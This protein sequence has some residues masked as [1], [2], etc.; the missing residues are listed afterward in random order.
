MSNCGSLR[1]PKACLNYII[2]YVRFFIVRAQAKNLSM[3]RLAAVSIAKQ[4]SSC[5]TATYRYYIIIPDRNSMR[6]MSQFMTARSIHGG[7]AANSRPPR[8]Q[9]IYY[10]IIPFRNSSFERK[11]RTLYYRASDIFT[12]RRRT[13][14][15]PIGD[16]FTR[17]A[18]R[19]SHLFRR[20]YPEQGKRF[21]DTDES[22]L[23]Y[24]HPESRSVG[25]F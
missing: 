23:G 19:A 10:I 17:A 3:P 14:P 18:R 15:S 21:F 6:R 13:S 25:V 9:F 8:G 24:L 1:K 4:A 20:F 22:R 11:R 2:I 7:F 12:R 5:R 16:N